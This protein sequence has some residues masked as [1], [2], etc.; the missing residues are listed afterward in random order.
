MIQVTQNRLSLAL[1]YY[2]PGKY[3]STNAHIAEWRYEG[4]W[5]ISNTPVIFKINRQNK[6]NQSYER[7]M[8]HESVAEISCHL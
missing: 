1:I 2:S 4:Y 6:H 3:T 5:H 8:E 7:K